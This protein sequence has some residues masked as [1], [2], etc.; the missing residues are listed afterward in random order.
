MN[1][2]A[3]IEETM[4]LPQRVVWNGA[5][6]RFHRTF[7]KGSEIVHQGEHPRAVRVVRSGWL[8]R[9]RQ[10]EDGRRQIVA[11]HLPGDLCDLDAFSRMRAEHSLVA[12]RTSVVAELPRHALGHL[13]ASC[14]ALGPVMAFS[15]IDGMATQ[16]E[17]LTSLGQRNAAERVA[18]LFC[19]LL[20][21]QSGE[22]RPGAG[23]CEFFLT[24][25]QLAE[26]CGLTQ[27]HINRTIQLLRRSYGV[28]LGK[29]RLHIADFARLAELA[30]FNPAYLN[31]DGSEGRH[32]FALFAHA[33]MSAGE[34]AWPLSPARLGA[35]S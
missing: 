1:F 4:P 28:D 9:Y 27:V 24:Q 32:D 23:E 34:S 17:W 25:S 8:A 10:L 35:A 6:E 14:P 31:I 19:E 29:S 33:A 11:L 13:I 16:R 7:P 26:A 22:V 12:L 2:S 20:V 30:M 18:H 5:V 15:E 3:L 21:R